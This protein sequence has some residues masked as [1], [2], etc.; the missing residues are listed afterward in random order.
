MSPCPSPDSGDACTTRRVRC[1]TGRCGKRAPLPPSPSVGNLGA[2]TPVALPEAK[3]RRPSV[4][5]GLVPRA[6]L[7]RRLVGS[8]DVP[9]AL[10]VAPAGYGKTTLL[11][12]WADRDRRPFVWVTLDED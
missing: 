3:R 8:S 1:A 6:R 9:L 12:Q 7:V 5:D 10:L 2:M 4:R 11:S